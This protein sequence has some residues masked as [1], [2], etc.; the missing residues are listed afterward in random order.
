MKKVVVYPGSFDPVTYG[1]LDIIKRA[2]KI[3]DKVIVAVAHDTEKDTLFDVSERVE[4]LK[5]TLRGLKGVEVTSI[6][7]LRE[8]E[9]SL[10]EVKARAISHFEEVFG[11]SLEGIR[12]DELEERLTQRP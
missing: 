5:Q 6:Q 7:R 12:L 2:L 9:V 8:S 10:T 11:L 4:I 1:H 3:S